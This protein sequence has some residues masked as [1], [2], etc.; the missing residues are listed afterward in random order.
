[1]R[2]L[3][4]Y[5]KDLPDGII[6]VLIAVLPDFGFSGME[7]FSNGLKAYSSEMDADMKGLQSFAESLSL[8]F[9]KNLIEEQNWNAAW[10]SNFEPVVIPG[11]IHVRAHFHEPIDHI[12]HEILI[13]PK[14][15]FG[16]GHHATTSMMMKAMLEQDLKGLS[17]IDFGTGTGIL[18]ILAEKL[19]AGEIDAI[20]NDQWSIN[21]AMENVL[22]N[23]ATQIKVQLLDTLQPLTPANIVLA[24]I[25]KSILLAHINDI[26]QKVLHGGKLIIS[27]LLSDDYNDIVSAYQS[28][29]G[30]PV[31][32]LSENGWIALVF[33]KRL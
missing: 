3:E 19:G 33:E 16:T 7:E 23:N 4:I 10:E 28:R 20:D 11:K 17:V 21:N 30:D 18:A 6:D 24:N 22:N 31:S 1:M 32:K 27:G 8:T 15:S 13:T 29:F 2:Y 5:F 9:S 25:N 12:E 14:M 26:D